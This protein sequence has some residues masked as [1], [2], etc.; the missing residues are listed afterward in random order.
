MGQSASDLPDI[1]GGDVDIVCSDGALRGITELITELAAEMAWKVPQRIQ[2]ETC[3]FYYVLWVPEARRFIKLD[4]CSD[5]MSK[6]RLLLPSVW[7]LERRQVVNRNGTRFHVAATDR[8]FGYYLLK[9]I[10]KGDANKKAIRHLAALFAAEPTACLAVLE[11]YWPSTEWLRIKH[12]ISSENEIDFAKSRSGWQRSLHRKLPRRGVGLVLAEVQRILK[13]VVQPTGW[14]TAFLGPDG[15]GKSTVLASLSANCA[16]LG[17]KTRSFHLVPPVP[18]GEKRGAPVS[19]PHAKPA[20][21]LFV[22]IVKLGYLVCR[23]NF[24]WVVSVLPDYRRSTMCYFDRY[25]HDMLADPKRYRLGTPTWLT[26]MVEWLIPKPNLFLVLDVSPEIACSRKKEVSEEESQKSFIAYRALAKEL[27]N[28]ILIDAN[29]TPVEVAA[30]CEKAVVEAMT[31]RT[32]R[33]GWLG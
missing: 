12:V 8:E 16:S 17:R 2:H 30:A 27:P 26:R 10:E 3:A 4:I 22:S 13:R 11:A 23:Y 14:V 25:Y 31:E 33:R 20:H 24:G 21:G 18:A 19:N 32:K 15:S 7:L 9:K 6:G 28:A 29:E 1:P 5:Y